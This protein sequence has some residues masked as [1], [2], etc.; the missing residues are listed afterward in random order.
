MFVQQFVTIDRPP[1]EVADLFEEEV[2]PKL[3]DLI[4]A[5]WRRRDAGVSSEP[6]SDSVGARRERVDGVVYAVRWPANGELERPEVDIDLEFSDYDVKSTHAQLAGQVR[7]PWLVRWSA[8][9]RA[10]ERRTMTAFD[11]LLTTLAAVLEL[12]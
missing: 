5:T 7:F 9:E 4:A 2:M 3:T 10:A 6:W 8:D 12:S 1:G 11:A